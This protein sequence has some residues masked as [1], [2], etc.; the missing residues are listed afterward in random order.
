M[1]VIETQIDTTSD[2]FRDNQEH[3]QNL[4][5]ELRDQ[6]KE[7]KS[8]RSD[9]AKKRHLE[10]G[11]LPVEKRLDLLLDHDS[12]FLELS[13]LAAKDMYDG[14]VHGAGSLAG[15]GQVHGRE[16]LIFANDARIKGGTVYP[17]GVKKTLRGQTIAMENHLPMINL[18][19]SGGAFLPLQSE[20]FPDID[21]GGRV[22]YNQAMMS[23]MGIPQITCVM[24]LCTAGAAYLPAMSDYSV[25]VDK[26]G[27]IFLGGPPLVR[28]A[29][30]EEV[31]SEDLG[32]AALHCR[33][34]GVSD[35]WAADDEEA[36]EIVRD[37]VEHLPAPKKE[38][39]LTR[40]VIPPLY[41]PKEI[42][43]IV[44]QKLTTPYEVSE[45]IARIVDGSEFLD[46]KKDYGPTLVCGLAYI[47]GIQ[48]GILANN[49][50]LF[51]D[52][53]KKA[54][55]FI[56]LCD[57]NKTPLVF[58]QNISGYMIG[59]DYERGGITKDGHKMVNA[60]ACASVPKFTV[61]IGASF[62]AGNYGMCGRAYAPR[63]LW[64]WPNAKI[65]VMGA[66]QAVGVLVS[67]KNEQLKREGRP[68]MSPEDVKAIAQP[69]VSAAEK[70]MNAYHS[71]AN[72]W[73]DGI[74]DPAQTR[75]VLGL[76][77]SAALNAP[78][79]SD[80]WGYGVFRM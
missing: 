48:V 8:D 49:G 14:R 9:K 2:D 56:Q 67:V 80:S 50:V 6:L 23:K 13:P 69:I 26:T 64:M 35:F 28:A 4:V 31:S 37:L 12:P 58:L 3:M 76:G 53:A 44:P 36:L 39:P 32:G 60:V 79:R 66:E 17:L 63:F 57:R 38:W 25:H 52:S 46:F 19:D 78:L 18:V 24:G 16:V 10:Q 73:D 27:A 34:S 62:G 70:E 72:L 75:D 42:Y 45:V 7:A 74:I 30:G 22:F 11:K 1:D 33:E 43:G 55:Q 77:L 41:D 71:T 54:T 20:L 15:I 47:H 51:S 68:P 5:N 40:E 59:R 65:G 21:D 61:I 29:T